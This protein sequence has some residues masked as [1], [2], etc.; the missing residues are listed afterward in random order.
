MGVKG[1]TSFLQAVRAIMDLAGVAYEKSLSNPEFT[2][3]TVA[4]DAYGFL[5]RAAAQ[6]EI[7]RQLVL[8]D[9]PDY[10]RGC[11]Q[12]VLWCEQLKNHGID[13]L[14]IFDGAAPPGKAETKQD[15]AMK[16]SAAL[17]KVRARQRRGQPAAEADVIAA[18]SGF[19]NGTFRQK[20]VVELK[21]AGFQARVAMN[22][23]DPE[24]AYAVQCGDAWAVMTVRSTP[25]LPPLL[26]APA[27]LAVHRHS[28]RLW[29]ALTSALRVQADGDLVTQGVEHVLLLPPPT[30]KRGPN[31]ATGEWVYHIQ[32]DTLR[33]AGAAA[34]LEVDRLI[35]GATTPKVDKPEKLALWLAA[36]LE[37]LGFRGLRAYAAIVGC[38]YGRVHGAGSL[39]AVRALY[40]L[41]SLT[42]DGIE[43]LGAAL[44]EELAGSQYLRTIKDQWAATMQAERVARQAEPESGPPVAHPEFTVQ[45]AI[46]AGLRRAIACYEDGLVFDCV[47]KQV[48]PRI[49]RA[50]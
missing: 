20:V 27:F 42:G 13:V 21:A 38:D 28:P 37:K 43:Q 24:L 2:G 23:A 16:A 29:P 40:G 19:V 39:K 11:Q 41:D 36:I 47:A 26:G 48:R 4:V 14:A 34:R 35:D 25:M 8:P 3:K 1:A 49:G 7:A 45:S 50:S 46:A 18:A 32:A 33:S 12:I 10:D 31:F 15:R 17:A 30:D 22:E 9:T 6:L 5:H 44:A